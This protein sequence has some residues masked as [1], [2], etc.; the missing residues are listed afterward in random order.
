MTGGTGQTSQTGFGGG[1]SGFLQLSKA[2]SG[3]TGPG[4]MG[5]SDNRSSASTSNSLFSGMQTGGIRGGSSFNPQAQG[6]R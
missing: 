5:S 6:N 2:Q 3:L 4:T 1:G